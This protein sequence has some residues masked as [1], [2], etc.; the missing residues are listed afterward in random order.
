MFPKNDEFSIALSKNENLTPK[1]I[2]E[3]AKY[4]NSIDKEAPENKQKVKEQILENLSNNKSVPKEK[5]E[6]IKTDISR[7]V[8]MVYQGDETLQT[9]KHSY[10]SVKSKSVSLSAL[11][12]GFKKKL[13]QTAKKDKNLS[14]KR[15]R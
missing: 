11:M 6:E 5:R 1:T 3:L 8:N 15:E 10:D 2:N 7:F 13:N 4:A 9:F 12:D 14:L